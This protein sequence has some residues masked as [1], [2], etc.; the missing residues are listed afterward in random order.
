[1]LPQQL[2]ALT[3]DFF[4]WV[5]AADDHAGDFMLQDSLGTGGRAP[6]M[7]AWLQRDIQGSACC[8]LCPGGQGAAFGVGAAALGVPTFADD[9]SL[10]DENG[11]DHWIWA[12]AA[13]APVSQLQR[14]LH[15]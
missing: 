11:A 15:I 1:M 3:G 2:H 13:S 7:A 12:D 9:A 4:V 10:A 5:K 8:A 14:P 6:V